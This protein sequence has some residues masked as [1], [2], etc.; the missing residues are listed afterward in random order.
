MCGILLHFQPQ[1]DASILLK[2]E[3]LEFTEHSDSSQLCSDTSNIFN[4]IVPHVRARG[5][6]YSSF[7]TSREHSTS[8]FSS[9]LSLR[10]PFTTQSIEIHGR[11]VLQFNGELYN[12]E[13]KDNDTRFIAN[14]LH[15][16]DTGISEI[17][18][19]L[20]GEFAYTIYDK[21]ERMF[22]FGRDS[23]G[24][25]SLSYRLNESTGE[26]FVASVTGKE[27]E[28][29]DC[30]AGVIYTYD[31][32]TKT[33]KQKDVIRN[34]FSIC[35][36]IDKEMTNLGSSIEKLYKELK[37]STKKRVRSI[38]P[39]HIENSP[40]AVLFSGG[41][42]CSVVASLV[43]EELR[44]NS[45]DYQSISV[46]LLNVGFENPRTGIMP[47]ETPDRKLAT[48]SAKA[49]QALYPEIDIKLVEID[50]PYSE[51]LAYRPQV[52]DLMYPKNTEMDLS[53]AIA[54]FFASK[55]SGFVT[56]PDGSRDKYQRK[57]IVLFSGLG[58]DE[59]FG[60]YHKLAN[61]SSEE[62]TKELTRQINSIYDRN[63]NRDDKVIACNGVEVR[64]PFLDESLI[65]FSTGCIPLNYKVNKLILRKMA[66]EKLYLIGICDEP[67]RAI[68]FGT[69]SA[70]MTKDGNKH[71]TDLLK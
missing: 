65:T 61:K 48:S 14:L 53:I 40:I 71:G 59:L 58:A 18:R 34:P 46:E 43:L 33:L 20:D 19:S 36:D 27:E 64:Y 24:R 1:L 23:V 68:Q 56:L 45:G 28:F 9:V 22:Y 47:S 10:E 7:R 17:I 66:S 57:G 67:K 32:Q 16:D 50:V 4:K 69:K 70:K 30:I 15:L 2:N 38:H 3:L 60:G 26:L 49:L 55:G 12:E 62:L 41:L 37:F 52:V 13:I 54:F 63:L 25:R 6:N 5:P 44:E 11:Y 42:D 51:Y 35:E 8:W 31:T 21:K 29:V 39:M